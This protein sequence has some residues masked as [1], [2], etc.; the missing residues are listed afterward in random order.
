MFI[1]TQ[2]QPNITNQVFLFVTLCTIELLAV[3]MANSFYGYKKFSCNKK[4]VYILMNVI[5]PFF[6]L[7]KRKRDKNRW[8]TNLGVSI[9]KLI[10]AMVVPLN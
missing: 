8:A 3:W 10:N 6:A 2:N 7:K 5:F 9:I 4:N 1:R